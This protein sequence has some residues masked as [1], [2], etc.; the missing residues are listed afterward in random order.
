MAKDFDKAVKISILKRLM[1]AMDDEDK[2]KMV[3][4]SVSKLKPLKVAKA[5]DS[6]EEGKKVLEGLKKASESTPPKPKRRSV[7]ASDMDMFRDLLRKKGK[8]L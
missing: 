1:K 8:K 6:F 4:I 2:P 5:D 3:S 7:E